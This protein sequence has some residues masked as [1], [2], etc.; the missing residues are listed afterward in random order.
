MDPLEFFA[1]FANAMKRNPPHTEDAPMVKEL[2]QIGIVPGQD[3][4]ASKLTPEQIAALK[5]GA[6]AAI[7]RLETFVSTGAAHKTGWNSFQGELGR[8]G[9][10]YSARAITAR[11]AIGANPPE[12]AVYISD[13][14]DAG[15]QPLNGEAKYRMHFAA[16][17]LPPVSAFWSVT[18]YDKD[19]Y[20]IANPINRYAIGDRDKLKFNPDGS[21]DLYIQAQDPGPDGES[22]WLPSGDGVFNLTL[23]LYWPKPAVLNGSWRP[24]AVERVP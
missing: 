11:V 7:A 9:T 2:T 18:G 10:N 17:Q 19:G 5:A 8:Y 14:T 20:F 13:S 3:F 21:L 23:R 6:Q 24:P 16:G 15:G 22:N 4:D 12:D 1:A